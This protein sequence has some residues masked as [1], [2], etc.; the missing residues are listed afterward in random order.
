MTA[1][2][3]EKILTTPDLVALLAH[4]ASPRDFARLAQTSRNIFAET[5][6][7]A[8]REVRGIHNLLKLIPG[9]ECSHTGKYTEIWSLSIPEQESASL[10]RFNFYA[11][12]V[13][14]LYILPTPY[15]TYRFSDWKR[16]ADYGRLAVLLP[17]LR[18]LEYATDRYSD[19]ASIPWITPL[20]SPSILT[21]RTHSNLW[22][23]PSNCSFRHAVTLIKGLCDRNASLTDLSF[24]PIGTYLAGDEAANAFEDD[25]DLIGS[26]PLALGSLDN[27]GEALPNR[28][29]SFHDNLRSL[30]SLT[31]LTTTIFILHPTLLEAFASLPSLKELVLY[32]GYDTMLPAHEMS[33]VHPETT[34]FSL[35]RLELCSADIESVRR[36]WKLHSL[37]NRLRELVFT[38]PLNAFAFDEFGDVLP[39]FKDFV[40]QLHIR[41]PGIQS[42]AIDFASKQNPRI[43]VVPVSILQQL[44]LLPLHTLEMRHGSLQYIPEACQVLETCGTLRNLILE[45]QR[46]SYDDLISFSMIPGLEC[47]HTEVR[48]MDKNGLE[49]YKSTRPL[50]KSSV[51]FLHCSNSI[52]VR[53]NVS[54]EDVMGIIS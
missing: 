48:W 32:C 43:Y 7:Y 54:K 8:W 49:K 37:V 46:V 3:S 29:A 9:T 21:I 24:F 47:L 13:T 14:I 45:N 41:S 23:V 2:L 1:I 4:H 12:F 34:F 39:T 15:A 25:I 44:T 11:P 22:R 16:L 27:E 40:S 38:T 28:A 5:I 20:L 36:I 51:R 30:R 18:F 42:L 33:V 35:E 52:T 26:H 53:S 17:K 31:S 6:N 50:R 19:D 10:A